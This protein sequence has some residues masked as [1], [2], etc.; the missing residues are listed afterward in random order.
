M[1]RGKSI[2]FI[3]I[4]LLL[5]LLSSVVGFFALITIPLVIGALLLYLKLRPTNLAL[6]IASA[7]SLLGFLLS[8]FPNLDTVFWS[9]IALFFL[10]SL[11]DTGW[12]VFLLKIHLT[13]SLPSRFAQGRDSEVL[14]KVENASRMKIKVDL[15]D[16]IPKEAACSQLPWKG[17][18]PSGDFLEV[19]Y[20][21]STRQRGWATFR[22]TH[23]EVSGPLQLWSRMIR[24]GEREKVRV[25]PDYEPILRL[26]LLSMDNNPEQMGIVKKNWAGMSKEFHQLRDYHQGD[27][28][29]Q[30][31]WKASS[32]QQSLISR[33][34]HEQRDQTIII[35]IDCG[36]KMRAMDSGQSQ[37]DHCLNAMLLLAYIA[38]KQ[39]DNVGIMAY[40]GR[41]HYLPPV[42][43]V[44]SMTTILNH[45]FDYQTSASPSDYN[46]AVERIMTLQ[47]RR[48]MVVFL[49]NF[50]EEDASELIE[51]MKKLRQ[52]HIV[53][54]GNILETEVAKLMEKD[55]HS[56][57]DALKLA[58]IQGY[59]EGRRPAM[60]E[61]RDLNIPSVD[62][63]AG[64]LP[65]AL[66]NM[67]L[68]Q[69]EM[70]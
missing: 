61:L 37:F 63:T 41:E 34:Y 17:S 16:G 48:A 29:S 47:S 9:F 43:G 57:V 53:S 19:R 28:L 7:I 3:F 46:E 24:K 60:A 5:A 1:G 15:F 25:Y 62:V 67:Y 20:D 59:L 65:V 56:M 68:I 26:S 45:L 66:A 23:I 6:A 42:K 36:R 18:I 51:P 52:K 27:M 14:L 70:V 12:L 21:V 22:E 2:Y 50:R 58:G 44:G 39:G 30:I 8:I 64:E 4:L 11:I 13:R 49:S 54:I 40:G 55:V 38:L 31:D 69:R 10:L 33:D 35:A 32:K